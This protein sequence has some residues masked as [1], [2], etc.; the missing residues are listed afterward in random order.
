M[1]KF[2][3]APRSSTP[4]VAAPALQ[5][6][7]AIQHVKLAPLACIFKLMFVLRITSK[8]WTM[9][10]LCGSFSSGKNRCF[11]TPMI[12]HIATS[13]SKLIPGLYS[14]CFLPAPDQCSYYTM[15]LAAFSVVQTPL[16]PPFAP[17][18]SALITTME[19]PTAR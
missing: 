3:S 6:P 5:A 12:G 14:P 19:R 18:R 17:P 16:T 8:A 15:T 2:S 10:S 9:L 11:S 1:R 7:R 4:T 13:R